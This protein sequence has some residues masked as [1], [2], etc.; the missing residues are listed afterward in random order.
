MTIKERI[1][2]AEDEPSMRKNLND[3]LTSEGFT[4]EEAADGE[5]AARKIDE[6]NPGI[7][8]LD[9]NLPK[10]DGLQVLR[11]L[12]EKNLKSPVIVLTAYGTSE[13]AIEAMKL[14]AFEYLEKP[15]DL[16]EF[17]FTIKKAV[18]FI[19]T[20]NEFYSAAGKSAMVNI[21]NSE[22]TDYLIGRS[23]KMQ[24]IFKL[25]GKVAL[26]D[27]TVL[28]QGESGTGKE[29][30]ADAIQ[31]HSLRYN[32]PYVK[33][34]CGALTES[35]LESEIF[36]HEKGAFTGA[37]V[38]RR[39]K[40]EMAESGTIFLDEINN[41]PQSLQIK[42]LRVLQNQPFYRVGSESP[43]N[44]NVRIIA[45]SNIDVEEAVTKG[46]LRNDLFYR[47]NVVRINIPPL[48]SRTEDIPYLINYFLSKYKKDGSVIIADETMKLLMEYSWPGNIRELEN[49]IQRA[50][51]LSRSGVISPEHLP[52]QITESNPVQISEPT[53]TSLF[54]RVLHENK[55]FKEITGEVEN[56]LILSALKKSDGNRTKAAQLLKIHRRLLYTKMKEYNIKA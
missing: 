23:S 46:L 30:I 42:L 26:S 35:L 56:M 36:G 47:L 49:I 9:I 28:I 50:T 6:L 54:E 34:N 55:S 10:K 53:L 27:A 25:V 1:L 38:Q 33:V 7:I 12:K 52:V 39:G 32:K 4:V 40:F 45:A 8:L 20:L 41:M 16:D 2:I 31:R 51:V 15:F 3:L 44:I 24:E 13:K 43:I 17:L 14:G 21:V 48:K 37:A 22:P 18:E 5:E 11:E 29:L 19:N